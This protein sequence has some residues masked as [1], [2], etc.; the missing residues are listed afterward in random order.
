MSPASFWQ[1]DH[2]APSAWH[3]HAPFAFWLL[4]ALRPGIFVEL[5]THNG[6]SYLVFC[7]AVQRLGAASKCYAVD[8]WAGDDHAGFYGEEVFAKLSD[9]HDARY[10]GFSRL[11]RSTFDE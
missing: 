8:T 6:F 11:V 7:Q 9:F 1:P 4:D 3:Q 5:G 2:V 10:S